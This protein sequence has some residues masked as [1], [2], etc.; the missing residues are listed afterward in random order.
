LARRF[1]VLIDAEERREV[2]DVP[3]YAKLFLGCHVMRDFRPFNS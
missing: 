3:E 2:V 1:L